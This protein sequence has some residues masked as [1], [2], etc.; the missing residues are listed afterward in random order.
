MT[1]N[2]QLNATSCAV[3]K[4][5]PRES[6]DGEI[7]TSCT[8]LMKYNE[9]VNNVAMSTQ[10]ISDILL[11]YSLSRYSGHRVSQM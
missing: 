3:G 7:T 1:D 8:L 5:L 2:G 9:H 6:K 10:N 11:D 4:A